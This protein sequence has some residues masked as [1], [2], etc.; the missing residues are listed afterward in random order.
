MTKARW[1]PAAYGRFLALVTTVVLVLLASGYTTLRGAVDSSFAPILAA[2][3]ASG[4]AS[5]VSGALLTVRGGTAP[6]ALNRFL[7]AT[8]ARLVLVIVAAAWCL[9][10]L[11]VPQGPFLLWLVVSY[12]ALLAVDTV[13]AVK[14]VKSL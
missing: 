8:A 12:L 2:C 4:F 7:I 13:F 3:L 9:A 11:R 5:L 10:V 6:A 14:A 1:S